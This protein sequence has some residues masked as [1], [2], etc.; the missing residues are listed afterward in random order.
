MVNLKPVPYPEHLNLARIPTPIVPLNHV[1]GTLENYNVYM[2]RDDMTGVEL[3]GN[4]I[5]KLDF[6]IR[7]AMDKQATH[8]I[9]CGGL[10]SN[11]CRA[12]AFAGIRQ[13]LNVVLFLRGEKPDVYHGNYFLNH[14]AGVTIEY[15]NAEQYKEVDALMSDYARSHKGSY[16]IIPEGGS[17][18]IGA[19]GYVRCYSEIVSQVDEMNL[20]IDTIVVATGSG[21]THAGLLLGKYLTGGAIDVV[22]V[23]VCDSAAFFKEKIST[24]M[25]KFASRYSIPLS[26]KAGDIHIIDGFVG[27]G[28]GIIS[29]SEVSVIETC[30]KTEGII[31]DPVYGAK[32]FAGMT[33]HLYN[34]K[35]PGR[36]ILFIHTGGIFGIFPYWEKFS[37]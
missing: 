24:V 20:K 29:N 4:K 31:L 15:I 25:E 10:H 26:R 7:D 28:Y 11:H 5:R 34:G 3:S 22:S 9:T 14:L 18:E 2:K 33:D 35:L 16:Y 19:W 30:A 8:L 17:N 21:G 13:G 23:N 37:G 12:T 27:G 6:L 36:D 32:A 1:F